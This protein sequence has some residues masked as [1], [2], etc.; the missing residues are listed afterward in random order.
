M[1]HPP[2]A[3]GA[4]PQATPP[5]LILRSPDELGEAYLD[6]LKA[7]L[8]CRSRGIEPPPPLVEAWDHFYGFYAPRLQ[9]FLKRSGL[10][11]ADRHD[12]FQDVWKE[13]VAGLGRFRHDPSRGLLSTWLMTLA[14]NKAADSTRRRSR[15]PAQSLA[16]DD[17]Q[18]PP[19]RG[20]DPAAE[21]ERRRTQDQVRRVLVELAGQVSQISFQVLYLRWIEGRPT[22]EVAAALELTPRQVRFR[23]CR[24]M[25]KLRALFQ[26]SNEWD[27]SI[28]DQND[29]ARNTS[30]D[31]AS[32]Q[33]GER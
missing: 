3:T 11:E 21:Y 29:L 30:S 5:E 18:L 33:V 31:P 6:A 27:S 14:R 20:L 19:D 23:T 9:A 13:V 25:R 24:M 1:R 7:F 28:E 10:T 15:R 4:T 16:E 17:A 12:C 26:R 32:K 8:N 2:I 22:A